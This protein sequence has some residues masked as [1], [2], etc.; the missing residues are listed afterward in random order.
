MNSVS[1]LGDIIR[2][3]SEIIYVS[4]FYSW[5][6]KKKYTL[7]RK[8]LLFLNFKVVFEFLHW[9]ILPFL[10]Q[11]IKI[12]TFTLKTKQYLANSVFIVY[13]LANIDCFL[14]ILAMSSWN[15]SQCWG[16]HVLLNIDALVARNNLP[17]QCQYF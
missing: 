6:I 1:A 10:Q 16:M 7:L 3:V 17:F 9:N 8:F 11:S 15:I 4:I 5:S 13:I 2:N 12:L 14:P